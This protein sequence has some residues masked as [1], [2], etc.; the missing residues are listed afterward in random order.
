MGV[1]RMGRWGTDEGQQEGTDGRCTREEE[2]G[3]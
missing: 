3:S 2:Q 1:V